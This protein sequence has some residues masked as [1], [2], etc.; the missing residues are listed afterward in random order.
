MRRRK[1]KEEGERERGV[2]CH[3][4]YCCHT[5]LKATIIILAA[6]IRQ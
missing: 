1:R 6:I 4:P 3:A 2:V 5:T